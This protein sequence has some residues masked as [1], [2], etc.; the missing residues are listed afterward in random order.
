M[1]PTSL[2][3]AIHVIGADSQHRIA[4][5]AAPLGDSPVSDSIC[6]LVVE[7]KEAI[8]VGDAAADGRFAYSSLVAGDAPVR[9]YASFPMRTGEGEVIGTVCAFD[10]VVGELSDQA[11]GLVEDIALQASTH[12]DL[13]RLVGDPAADA[14]RDELTETANRLVIGDRLAHHLARIRRHGTQLLVATVSIEGHAE[15]STSL[16]HSAGDRLL[17]EVA[18][19]LASRVRAEDLI[20]RVGEHGFV[21]LAELP[22]QGLDLESFRERLGGALTRPFTIRGKLVE[23][24][25][26]VGAV[27]AESDESASEILARADAEMQLRD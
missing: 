25:A 13:M 26:R 17:Q 11:A 19:R 14:S 2:R 22:E 6:R 23:A 8:V 10:T 16:G 3:R 9:F 5:Y 4:G 24:G 18:R 12:L 1:S 15:V 7:S 27:I 20:A 21:V